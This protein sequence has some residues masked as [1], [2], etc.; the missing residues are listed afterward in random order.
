MADLPYLQVT[1]AKDLLR[2]SW[3]NGKAPKDNF[4]CGCLILFWIVWAPLTF[5]VTCLFALAE[6]WQDV[7][8]LAVWCSFGWLGTL[9]IPRGL[10]GCSWSEWIE[11]SPSSLTYGQLG[12][13]APKPRTYPLEP[14]RELTLGWYD[15]ESMVTLS[16]VWWSP[17]WKTQIQRRVL[18]AYWLAPSLKEEIFL[19]LSGFVVAHQV[20]LEL[21]R[22]PGSE[23]ERR[24][25]G[26]EKTSHHQSDSLR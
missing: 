22:Y 24:R 16:L 9:F 15:G 1:E 7:L 5:V 21:K 3:E 8:F 4:T 2:L 6:T 10:L 17:L 26:A 12:F 25:S 18:L 20:P 11:V 23:P 13:L 14:G 19:A